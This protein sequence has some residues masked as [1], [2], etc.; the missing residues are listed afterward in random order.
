M[1]KIIVIALLTVVCSVAVNAQSRS[2]G[3]KLGYGIEATYQH[4]LGEENVLSV[5]LG[6]PAFCGV[7]A[8]ATY[9]WLFP[10][11]KWTNKGSWNW[12]LGAGAGAGVFFNSIVN[13][14]VAGRVGIEYIFED[15]PLQLSVDFRPV[16]GPAF[17]PG[18]GVTFGGIGMGGGGIAA[19]YMF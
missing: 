10:I 1:K 13:V 9:D 11:P 5:D 6:F 8:V 7:N 15:I 16:I 18:D 19:R 14:G 12:F 3:G 4:W 2:I 17:A